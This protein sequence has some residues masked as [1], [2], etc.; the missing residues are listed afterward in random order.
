[1][2]KE[3]YRGAP[4]HP[5]GAII[6]LCL[7]YFWTLGEVGTGATGVGIGLIPFLVII[8]G[9]IAFVGVFG[10]QK[11]VARD[12]ILSSLSKAFAMAIIA[13]VPFPVAST[14]VGGILLSW[15]GLS[16]VGGFFSGSKSKN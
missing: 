14:A 1:M 12:G 8:L 5:L 13:A 7:D 6:V 9:I 11:F 4:V 10:I 3:K 2:K 15:A 16:A